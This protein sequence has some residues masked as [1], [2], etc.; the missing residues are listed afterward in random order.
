[1]DECQV[2]VVLGYAN[3]QNPPW[4][5]WAIVDSELFL[6]QEW[7]TPDFAELRTKLGVP[8]KRQYAS[9]LD[10]GLQMIQWAKAQHLPFTAVACDD[11]HGRDG[12]FRA[13]L[14]QAEICY[15]ADVPANTQ[16]YL[17]PP[18][19][20]LPEKTGQPRVLNQVRH[21]R[22]DRVGAEPDTVWQ[23]LFI[24][25]NE[26]GVLEDDFAARRVWNLEEG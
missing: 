12:H 16:V 6:A 3:W 14:D 21:L 19:I 8:A 24:P 10:L 1:M 7:F 22:V 4:R 20:G 15:Y 2:S 18:R 17:E 13:E 11:L 25:Y 9:K 23:R 5:I 26:R